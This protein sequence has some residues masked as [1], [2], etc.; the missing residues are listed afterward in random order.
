[1]MP[2]LLTLVSIVVLPV[3]AAYGIRLI[4]RGIAYVEQRTAT[5][6][7]AA[8]R[9]S[10]LWAE[11]TVG[12]AA[13]RVVTALNQT[14]VN[15][16]KATGQFDAAA[17]QKVFATALGQLKSTVDTKAL[18]ILTQATSNPTALLETLLNQAVA[19]APNRVAATAKTGTTTA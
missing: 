1:M 3:L 17:A 18:G 8:L 2:H 10:L 9:D 11:E 16:L 12:A 7:D 6:H 19:T 15:A 14:Q 13:D 4:N 5:I